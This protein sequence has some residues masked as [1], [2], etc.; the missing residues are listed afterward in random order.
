MS[1]TSFPYQR[2]FDRFAA[3]NLGEPSVILDTMM[4][5]RTGRNSR[6][7]QRVSVQDNTSYQQWKKYKIRDGRRRNALMPILRSNLYRVDYVFKRLKDFTGYGALPMQFDERTSG[8]SAPLYTLALNA[9][10]QV[11]RDASGVPTGL[12]SA[13]PMRTYERSSSGSWTSYLVHGHR[14]DGVPDTKLYDP[15]TNL[16]DNGGMGPAGFLKWTSVK[17]NFWGARK[18][19]TTFYVD[20]CRAFD[21]SDN[22][23]RYIQSTAST[24]DS[25]FP[26]SIGQHLD[27][28]MRPLTVNPISTANNQV[29]SP[30]KVL[31][32]IKVELDPVLTTEGD[33]D[34]HCKTVELFNRWGRTVRFDDAIDDNST[35]DTNANYGAPSVGTRDDNTSVV[36][37]LP[38]FDKMLFLVIRCNCFS[39]TSAAAFD[40]DI[41][42]SF[43][44]NFRSSWSKI[45]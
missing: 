23:Y 4:G 11:R 8:V 15:S 5:M 37:F 39:K 25:F 28:M 14:P 26:A 44:I 3:A 34:G 7:R 12:F 33:P 19:Q 38:A 18:K 43:D 13:S 35:F 30:W 16:E 22:P 6:K 36:Q 45:Q 29:P 9:V 17:F 21:S 27:E 32:R 24:P 42:P 31:K 40:P 10:S 41:N 20:I 1:Y 2:Q